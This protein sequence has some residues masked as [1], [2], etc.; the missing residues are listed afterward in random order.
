MSDRQLEV[1]VKC[2]ARHHPGAG[3]PA[4]RDNML[5][6]PTSSMVIANDKL[7]GAILDD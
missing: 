2:A 3:S 4:S 7:T 5:E 6:R 1:Y